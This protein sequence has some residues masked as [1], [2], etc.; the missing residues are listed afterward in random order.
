MAPL[1]PGWNR[2]IESEPAT[3]SSPAKSSRPLDK[4]HLHH[5]TCLLMR[6]LLF[7]V[8]LLISLLPS[9]AQAETIRVASISFR[10]QKLGLSQ[11]EVAD[12]LRNIGH[13]V[14]YA[15]LPHGGGQ[16]IMI[17]DNKVLVGGSDPRKDGIALGI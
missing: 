16:A 14:E 7:V 5:P 10:P 11:K 4:R 13:K 12:K 3:R 1:M 8:I 15:D 2:P 9:A 17:K 6:S